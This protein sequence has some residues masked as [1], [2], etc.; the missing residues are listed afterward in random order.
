MGGAP[1]DELGRFFR[2]ES[3][4]LRIMRDLGHPHLIKAISA[5]E[6]GPEYCFVFPWAPKG[7]LRELWSRNPGSANRRVMLWAWAQIRGLTDG[8]KRLH[9]EKHRHGDVKP[10]NIL[11]F[12]SDDDSGLGEL[13]IA[14]VGI[15]KFHADETRERQIQGYVTTNRNGTLR[16]EPP[17]VQLYL[18]TGMV[19]SRRYD[20][21][22]LGCVLLEF[23]IW[24]L[25]GKDGQTDFNKE[26]RDAT[27]NFDRF[28]HQN[29]SGDPIL[30]PVVER[31]VTQEL[32]NH[33]QASPALQELLDLV[34]RHLLVALLDGPPTPRATMQKFWN[35]LENINNICAAS[36][37]YL[38]NGKTMLTSRRTSATE[39]VNDDTGP[40]SQRVCFTSRFGFSFSMTDLDIVCES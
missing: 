24:L 36:P 17:E 2:R 8:L 13:V 1:A 33:S 30:H 25:R 27:P 11:I 29:D 34:A 31:W 22:S 16:Y 10:E 21:W 19:I 14:D 12:D 26:R 15:A 20:S 38:W 4:T 28:W 18:N 9:E 32:P 3:R 35:D 40:I 5:Y 23:I 37:S 6:K 39:A 7:N